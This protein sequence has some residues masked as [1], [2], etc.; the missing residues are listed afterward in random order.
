MAKTQI[1]TLTVKETP[2]WKLNIMDWLK[3]LLMATGTPVLVVIQQSIDKGE[4]TF[5][6]KVLAMTALGAGLVYIIKNL[7]TSSVTKLK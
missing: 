5:N 1:K 3:G 2:A 7:A 4:L 6:W